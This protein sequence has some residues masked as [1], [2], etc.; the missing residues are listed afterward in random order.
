VIRADR[1]AV[2]DAWVDE[3][4]E[5]GPIAADARVGGAFELGLRPK[6]GS[7][8]FAATGTYQAVER[9]VRLEFTWR[10]SNAPLETVVTVEF[11]EVDGG[12]EVIVTH[13]GFPNAEARDQHADGWTKCVERMRAA[14]D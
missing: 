7:D 11:R 6:D 2:F 14:L 8:G 5:N 1:E 10:W 3:G 9:P 4:M 13:T 12:T